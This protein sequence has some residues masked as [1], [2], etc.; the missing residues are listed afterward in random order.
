MSNPILELSN[1]LASA[2]ES[3]GKSVVRVDAG[4]WTGSTGIVWSADGFVIT[5]AHTL[6]R[7]DVEVTL[8]GEQSR[9]ASVVG[10]DLATDL[11][12]LRLEAAELPVPKWADPEGLRVGQMVLALGW[13]GKRLR[14]SLGILSNVAGEWRTPMGGRL[15]R[16]VQPDVSLYPGFSGGPLVDAE[17][18]F[19]GLNTQALRRGLALTLT[20]PTLR[21]V[22]EALQKHGT[23]RRGYLGVSA[24]PVRLPEGAGQGVGLLLVSVEESGPAE[25]AG[26]MVGDVLLALDGR[27]LERLEELLGILGELSGGTQVRLKLWRGGQI[28]ELGVKLGER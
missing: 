1:A 14:A 11:A 8:P 3:A 16:Y 20:L 10:R 18:R 15:E 7:S 13:P 4:R 21:R 27:P 24:Q 19:I 5:A 2:V 6:R 9:E 17:G 22:V 12:L 25:Q 23:V 28:H 26:L